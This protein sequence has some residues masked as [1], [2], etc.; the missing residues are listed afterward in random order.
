MPGDVKGCEKNR[1]KSRTEKREWHS[2]PSDRAVKDGPS[3]VLM[4]EWVSCR[5][6]KEGAVR[7]EETAGQR[8]LFEE[9]PRQTS[10][11]AMK[12]WFLGPPLPP[13]CPARQSPFFYYRGCPVRTNSG[14]AACCTGMLPQRPYG[15]QRAWIIHHLTPS[16]KCLL[17][18]M[19][20][21]ALF[22]GGAMDITERNSVDIF[23][24]MK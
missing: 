17:T 7:V 23:M 19:L 15:L 14:P 10:D 9:K 2:V 12:T 24:T 20:Y 16:R 4:V 1:G 8:H 18:P 11:G 13:C 3:G 5:M 22:G 6:S 21:H